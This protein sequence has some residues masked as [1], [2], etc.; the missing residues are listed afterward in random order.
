[1]GFY[2]ET[3]HTLGKADFL[4]ENEGAEELTGIAEIEKAMEE[5]YGVI[6]VVN[7]H[8]L[9][10][11]AAFAYDSNELRRFMRPDNRSKR[12]LKMDRKR[13]EKL[14]GYIQADKIT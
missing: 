3:P 11:A 12:W 6:S 7:N 2:I 5:G 8:V 9:F 10:E 4:I 13:A 1:M 14:A